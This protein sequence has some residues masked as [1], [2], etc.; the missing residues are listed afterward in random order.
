MLS[1]RQIGSFDYDLHDNANAFISLFFAG[2]MAALYFF[3]HA[4]GRLRK[5]GGFMIAALSGAS[6]ASFIYLSQFA[7][8]WVRLG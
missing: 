6:F 1:G 5:F 2:A 3:D 4:R 8:L 7:E